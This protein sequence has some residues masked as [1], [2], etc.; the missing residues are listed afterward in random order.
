MAGTEGWWAATVGWLGTGGMAGAEGWLDQRGMAVTKGWL[1]QRDGWN[2][3][4]AVWLSQED[5]VG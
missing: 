5:T 3:D 1:D 2:R 4:M